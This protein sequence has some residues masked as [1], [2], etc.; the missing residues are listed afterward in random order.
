MRR[1]E[2]ARNEGSTGSQR[3]AHENTQRTARDQLKGRDELE[4][5]E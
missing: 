1:P 3:L 5:R 2:R 4:A